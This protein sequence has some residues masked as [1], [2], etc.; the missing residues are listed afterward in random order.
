MGGYGGGKGGN[1]NPWAM[2]QL[3][4]MTGGKGMGAMGMGKGMGKGG[5]GAQQGNYCQH[6]QSHPAIF[7]PR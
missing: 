6:A 1:M 3:L 4:Y 2:M 5:W 7:N